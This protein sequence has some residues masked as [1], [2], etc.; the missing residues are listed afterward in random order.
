MT[1]LELNIRCEIAA[2]ILTETIISVT[3]IARWTGLTR[4]QVIAV[5]KQVGPR[6]IL[7]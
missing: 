5:H 6:N 1:E 2:R 7:H 4:E 3:R